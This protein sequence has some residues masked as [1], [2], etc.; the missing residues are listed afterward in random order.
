MRFLGVVIDADGSREIGFRRAVRRLIG[1]VLAVIPFGLG[2]LGVALGER[3][4]GLQDVIARTEVLY[5]EPLRP[6]A[7][8]A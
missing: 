4:R 8:L 1:L 7:I 6:G 5:V 3:R 2:F